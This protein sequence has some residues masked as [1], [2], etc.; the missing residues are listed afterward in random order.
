MK[1]IDCPGCGDKIILLPKTVQIQRSQRMAVSKTTSVRLPEKM[2]E[3]ID[4]LCNGIGCSRNDW[5]KDKLKDGLREENNEIEDPQQKDV[6]TPITM[7]LEKNLLEAIDNK[8]EGLGCN[9]T[10][11]ITEALQ[12]K[13]DNKTGF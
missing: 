10:D 12:K 8:C 4:E 6:K 13:L 7:R 9:R 3:E 1:E 5:I 11:F 2:L